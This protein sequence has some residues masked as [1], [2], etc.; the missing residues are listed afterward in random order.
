MLTLASGMFLILSVPGAFNQKGMRR[1]WLSI[2]LLMI[3]VLC[4]ASCGGSSGS[5]N[6]GTGGGPSQPTT[7]TVSVQATAHAVTKNIGNV[8]VTVP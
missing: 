5:S 3:G 8:T 6:G 7:F 2:S 4:V 1:R